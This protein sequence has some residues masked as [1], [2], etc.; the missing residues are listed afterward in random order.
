M[1]DRVVITARVDRSQKG[2]V[3]QL[4]QDKIIATVPGQKPDWT[5]L[6]VKTFGTAFN[7]SKQSQVREFVRRIEDR[8]GSGLIDQPDFKRLKMPPAIADSDV[9]VSTVMQTFANK[10]IANVPKDEPK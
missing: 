4:V 9:K 1:T 2:P 6:G 7:V 8:V 3:T 10:L 5:V